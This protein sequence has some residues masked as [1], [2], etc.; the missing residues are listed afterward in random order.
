MAVCIRMKVLWELIPHHV[1][2]VW[3]AVMLSL[4]APAVVG[5][6]VGVVGARV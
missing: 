5:V 3:A 4:T 1:E 2:A 6:E